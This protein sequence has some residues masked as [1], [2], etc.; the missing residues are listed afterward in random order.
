MKAPFS[1]MYSPPRAKVLSVTLPAFA[2]KT[3]MMSFAA[4]SVLVSSMVPEF[5]TL[6]PFSKR[7]AAP[8]LRAAAVMVSFEP[9]PTVTVSADEEGAAAAVLSDD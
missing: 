6:P 3:G 8:P 4:T 2:P 1:M 9:L 5:L 7:T